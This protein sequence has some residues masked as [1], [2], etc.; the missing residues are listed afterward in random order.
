[1]RNMKVAK[2][3][4]GKKVKDNKEAKRGNEREEER[5]EIGVT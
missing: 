5:G 2:E 1:M 3:W 4:E